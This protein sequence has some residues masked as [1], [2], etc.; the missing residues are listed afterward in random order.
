MNSLKARNLEHP[1]GPSDDE[2][3]SKFI[4]FTKKQPLFFPEICFL[5]EFVLFV[6]IY[7]LPTIQID[8]KYKCMLLCFFGFKVSHSCCV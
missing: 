5:R 8:G 6:V 7:A 4:I 3:E 2:D 1:M